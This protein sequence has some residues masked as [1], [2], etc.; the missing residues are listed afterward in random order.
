MTAAVGWA[1]VGPRGKVYQQTVRSAKK[2]A[3]DAAYK[4]KF[5]SEWTGELHSGYRIAR[6]RIEVIEGSDGE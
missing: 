3:W 6:V 1:V 4:Y 2:Y 5:A